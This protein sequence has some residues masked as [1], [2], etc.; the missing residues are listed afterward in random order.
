MGEL[1]GMSA[2][3]PLRWSVRFRERGGPRAYREEGWGVGVLQGPAAL[4]VKDAAPR[5]DAATAQMLRAGGP[6]RG[7]T[8]LAYI[9]RWT[10]SASLANAH[11]FVRE[12]QGSEWAFAHNGNVSEL[13]RDPAWVPQ[14]YRPVGTTDS[15]YAFCALLDRLALAAATSPLAR[16]ARDAAGAL[17]LSAVLGPLSGSVARYGMFNYL[18][19][20][21]RC[22]VAFSSGEYGLYLLERPSAPDPL[23]LHD[24]DWEMELRD[25]GGGPL[26]VAATNP[27]TDGPWERLGPGEIAVAIDGRVAVRRRPEG[28]GRGGRGRP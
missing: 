9:R 27:M 19:A 7:E 15:E 20:T 17:A 12:M 18:L 3:R 4:V 5:P 14:R 22:L 26:V 1:F 16:P 21:E 6:L 23:E 25:G 11:P 8:A 24:E 2:D 28:T 10:H 13:M